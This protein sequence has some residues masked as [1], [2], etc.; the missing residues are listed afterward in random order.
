MDDLEDICE[1]ANAGAAT[2]DEEAVD[3]RARAE[4][5]SLDEE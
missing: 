3:V 2:L 5:W 4:G 1:V